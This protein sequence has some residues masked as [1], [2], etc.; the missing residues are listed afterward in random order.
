MP[1]SELVFK[2]FFC[3]DAR[4]IVNSA[5]HYN[6]SLCYNIVQLHILNYSQMHQGGNYQDFLKLKIEGWGI[7]SHSLIIIKWTWGVFFPKCAIWPPSPLDLSSNC[8]VLVSSAA[9]LS[10]LWGELVLPSYYEKYIVYILQ[11]RFSK[12]F[13]SSTCWKSPK[14]YSAIRRLYF[15]LKKVNISHHLQPHRIITWIK[16]IFAPKILHQKLHIY[17]Y[18]FSLQLLQRNRALIVNS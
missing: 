3:R 8:L 6:F 5:L 7:F 18:R 13:L 16:R 2:F 17:Q 11:W 14:T 15:Y 1:E 9:S 12:V 10:I 4:K